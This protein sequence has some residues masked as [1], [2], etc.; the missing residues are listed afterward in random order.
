MIPAIGD[1]L[2][3]PRFIK[4]RVAELRATTAEKCSV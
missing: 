1:P 2:E 3:V 4:E